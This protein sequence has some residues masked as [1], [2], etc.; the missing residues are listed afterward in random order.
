VGG[1]DLGEGALENGAEGVVLGV[2]GHHFGDAPDA[3]VGEG[4]GGATEESRTGRPRLV[5]EDL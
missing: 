4:R 2:V 5:T 1:A 3:G